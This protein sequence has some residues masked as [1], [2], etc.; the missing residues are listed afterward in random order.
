MSIN[1]INAQKTVAKVTVFLL[2]QKP[3]LDGKT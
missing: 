1:L 3:D 2:K